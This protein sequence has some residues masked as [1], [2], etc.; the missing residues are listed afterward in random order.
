MSLARLIT[1]AIFI[2]GGGLLVI[3]H[4]SVGET[5]ARWRYKLFGRVGALDQSM[6]PDQ[7]VGLAEASSIVGGCVFIVFGIVEVATAW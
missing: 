6:R 2:L 7:V 1:G 3:F 4:R 5:A